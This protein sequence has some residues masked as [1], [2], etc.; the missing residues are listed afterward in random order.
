MKRRLS[1]SALG[2]AALTSGLSLVLPSLAGAELA[3]APPALDARLY[4]LAEAPSAQRI[5]QDIRRL[6]S[7]G[8]RN[9]LSATD[10]DTRGI[11][12]ARRFVRDE[13]ERISAACGG[14]LEVRLQR[15]LVPGD[16]K[17]R[18]PV[19]TEVVNVFAILR[20]SDPSRYVLMAGDIDSRGSN[21]SDGV[22]DAPGANDNA[23]GLAG[24]LE[25]A[26]V[27]A[28]SGPRSASVVFAALSGEEQGLYGGAHLAALAREEG[29]GLEAVLNNDMIGNIAGI[30]GII[31]NAEFRVFS[32]A[33]PVPE[34]QP[35]GWNYRRY[36]GEV[37]G[38]SRQLARRVATLTK[39]FFPKLQAR[40]VYRLDRFGRGGHHT[41]FNN[42]GFP[43][44]RIMESHEHYER[45]HQ[46]L[47]T[48]EGV[49]YG[50]TLDFVDFKHAAALTGVNVV[51][52]ASLASA[53]RAP[54]D[55]AI[56]GVVAPDT[57][58][59][60]TASEEPALAGYRLYWR[61]T[62]APQW[63][64]SRWLGQVTHTTLEG[65]VIDN[66]LFGVAA[67]GRDG[68]ESVVAFPTAVL[69]SRP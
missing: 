4:A 37:D 56:G 17:T 63:T 57:W 62:D 13:F 59:S 21:P 22:T 34:Y 53:P 26:R 69:R 51:T 39:Q 23:S 68:N 7:F 33:V 44:V 18:I 2:L 47:R 61:E 10:S 27:L 29:W 58:L 3:P 16:P 20:G 52:L 28:A 64:H 55:V 15:T 45:Q 40:M 32:E 30:D 49:T 19:D 46:D 12:A 9:T 11:G 14:C 38:P 1:L 65:M 36:G 8:T 60:W 5:E 6:V 31:S 54:Q 67:V 48:E 42:A 41:P 43:G 66:Y 25:A 35:K 24:V 50:D